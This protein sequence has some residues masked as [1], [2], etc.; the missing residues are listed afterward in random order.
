MG[1]YSLRLPQILPPIILGN[2]P[3]G[4]MPRFQ[5]LSFLFVD[6]VQMLRRPMEQ[7]R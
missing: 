1:A 7:V 6:L 5:M 2:L 3:G 4:I